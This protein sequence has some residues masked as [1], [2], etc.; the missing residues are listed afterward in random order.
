MV[1]KVLDGLL[2][3]S[4]TAQIRDAVSKF[5]MNRRVTEIQ[6]NFLKRLL[7]SKAGMVVI[8]FR[9]MQSLPERRN[10]EAFKKASKFEKGLANFAQRT[11]KKALDSFKNEFEEGQAQKKRAVIQL[12]ECTQGGQ[13]KLY[14]RWRLLSEKKKLMDEC[15]QMNNLFQT[16]FFAIKSTADMV[17]AE[18]KESAFKEKALLQLFKNLSGNVSDTFRRW[19]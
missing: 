6:R 2:K 14:N 13:K 7:M 17:F 9:K 10:M 4:R 3:N 12:I 18:N 1:L 16:L 5:R 8:A 11:L 15:R 19:R